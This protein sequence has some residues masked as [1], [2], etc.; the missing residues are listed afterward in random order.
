[1]VADG[2]AAAQKQ[3]SAQPLF[4]CED[5]KFQVGDISYIQTKQGVLYPRF[6]IYVTTAL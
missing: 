1:M 2:S 6:W 4:L 5:P 3:K